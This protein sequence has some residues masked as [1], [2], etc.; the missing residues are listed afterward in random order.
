[1][2]KRLPDGKGQENVREGVFDSVIALLKEMRTPTSQNKVRK[3]EI[4]VPAGQSITVEDLGKD[5]EVSKPQPQKKANTS[6]T[7]DEEAE[8]I[9]TN[10]DS[11]GGEWNEEFSSESEHD[12]QEQECEQVEARGLKAEDFVT[13]NYFG[14]QYPGKVIDFNEAEETVRVRCM[15]KCTKQS[16]WKWPESNDE[17][18]YSSSDVVMK[19]KQP[20]VMANGYFTK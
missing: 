18:S 1:M 20:V 15:K 2:L 11:A 13:V 4:N 10:T 12:E 7:E 19:I 5:Q 6:S 9:L 3:K 14:V 17:M 8:P 16:S